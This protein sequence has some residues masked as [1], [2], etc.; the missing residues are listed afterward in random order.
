MNILVFEPITI[1]TRSTYG[2]LQIYS[3][4]FQ[5]CYIY[6]LR[7]IFLCQFNVGDKIIPMTTEDNT[8]SA[9]RITLYTKLER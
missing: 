1:M 2:I 8:S 5:K 7:S 4:T 3:M 6:D 9:V